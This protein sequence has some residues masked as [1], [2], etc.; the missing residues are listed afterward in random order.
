MNLLKKIN[1]SGTTVIMVTHDETLTKYM[2]RLFY[3][4][5]GNIDCNTVLK[6]SIYI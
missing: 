3:I 6:N 1:D 5:D 4:K 2:T